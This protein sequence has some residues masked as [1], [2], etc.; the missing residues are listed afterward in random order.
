MT[1]TVRVKHNGPGHH[2]VQVAITRQPDNV[3]V[4]TEVLHENDSKDFY[5]YDSQGLTI[6]EVPRVR[7]KQELASSDV[8]DLG[9]TLGKF[10]GET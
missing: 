8:G 3:V 4:S 7:E 9:A 6:T 5:V 2:D 10:T 1:T